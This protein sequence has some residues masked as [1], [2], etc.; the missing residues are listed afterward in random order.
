M[1][2]IAPITSNGS[3]TQTPVGDMVREVLMV[4]CR[5]VRPF[6]GQPRQYFK[7]SSLQELADS[8]A[9]VGQVTPALVRRLDTLE[10]GYE[11]ELIEGERR[12]RACIMLD[13]P[14]KVEVDIDTKNDRKLQYKK[15]VAANFGREG[16]TPIESARAIKK[17]R[18]DGETIKSV[19]DIMGKSMGWVNQY[20]NLLKLDPQ[21]ITLLEPQHTEEEKLIPVS[22]GFMLVEVP[23]PYQ[24]HLAK[25]ISEHNLSM[26]S[27]R[28]LIHATLHD[29]GITQTLRPHREFGRISMNAKK[30]LG[31][32]TSLLEM[33]NAQLQ[34]IVK[35][36]GLQRRMALLEQV[37]G[38]SKKA[39]ELEK[40]LKKLYQEM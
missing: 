10:D 11:F 34:H 14:L 7:K 17:L 40:K 28:N 4:P 13:R 36:A 23:M 5:K 39:Q 18:E 15:S 16:H 1:S 24:L 2:A 8:I 33:P 27:A 19:A 12:F 31:H 32:L 21:V 30:T 9:E 25:R 3:H 38:I 22:I 20:S 29:R 26:D 6:D 37:A 35:P